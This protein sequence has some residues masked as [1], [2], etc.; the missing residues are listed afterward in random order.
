[1]AAAPPHPA[2]SGPKV[3]AA[4]R[5]EWAAEGTLAGLRSL[6]V[7]FATCLALAAGAAMAGYADRRH[8]SRANL[9]PA[10]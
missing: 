2:A 6:Q 4:L 8:R 7:I 9:N 3:A 1:V 5:R 10:A